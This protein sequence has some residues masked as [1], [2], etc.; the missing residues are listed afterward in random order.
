[1]STIVRPEQALAE[2]ALARLGAR[3]APRAGRRSMGFTLARTLELVDAEA[4]VDVAELVPEVVTWN[5]DLFGH[6]GHPLRDPRTQLIVGDVRRIANARTPTTPCFDVDN[7]PARL[8]HPD[9]GG[10]TNRG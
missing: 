8:S 1:M 3:S 6:R 9:N 7:G 2:L 10:S 4:T 5:R